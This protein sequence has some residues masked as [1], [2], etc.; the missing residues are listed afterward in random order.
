MLLPRWL[1]CPFEFLLLVYCFWDSGLRRKG[2]T[3]H[4]ERV[5]GEEKRRQQ[6]VA[7]KGRLG[8]MKLSSLLGGGGL[9][10]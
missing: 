5:M 9:Q 3:S 2:L 8:V 4:L 6:V 7:V 10:R 1:R